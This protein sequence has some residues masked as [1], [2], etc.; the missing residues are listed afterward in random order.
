MGETY[1]ANYIAAASALFAAI[2][3]GLSLIGLRM[4]RVSFGEQL[5]AQRKL[6]AEQQA[7][8]SVR[9]YLE[10]SL[11][12]PKLSSTSVNDLHDTFASVVLLMAK[13]VM[14]AYPRDKNWEQL[15]YSQ[16]EFFGDT[17]AKWVEYYDKYEPEKDGRYFKEFGKDVE[18]LVNKALAE[19]KSK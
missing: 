3:A 16:L 2:S 14:E 5:A 8:E 10:L 1:V 15:M 9:R 11:Q 13:D 18:R 7:A 12:Y 17:F 6:I 4:Q 19:Q